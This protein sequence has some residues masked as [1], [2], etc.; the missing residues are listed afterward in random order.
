MKL[1]LPS[2]TL[3][4]I[5]LEN[6][7][8]C[9]F[10][11]HHGRIDGWFE[12]VLLKS[13]DKLADSAVFCDAKRTVWYPEEIGLSQMELGNCSVS[14]SWAVR[15]RMFDNASV[16][17]SWMCLLLSPSIIHW[18][19]SCVCTTLVVLRLYWS[20]KDWSF[21]NYWFPRPLIFLGLPPPYFSPR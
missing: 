16:N 10:G 7:T 12:V 15:M 2:S 17:Q 6:S 5:E 4:K 11:T 1:N 20:S 13:A 14:L 9:F 21:R 3:T 19:L 18:D 8:Q